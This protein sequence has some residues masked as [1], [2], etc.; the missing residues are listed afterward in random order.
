MAQYD[1]SKHCTAG[2]SEHEAEVRD[3]VE[4]RD[5]GLMCE[6]HYRAI[7]DDSAEVERLRG[8]LGEV[9]DIAEQAL[10]YDPWDVAE[11]EAGYTHAAA[12][13]AV[14]RVRR[15]SGLTRPA[16]PERRT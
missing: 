14:V 15:E 6:E 3:D 4:W 16:D 13:L 9:L 2:S 1:E 11:G 10:G 7:F 12:G 5:L 8:L